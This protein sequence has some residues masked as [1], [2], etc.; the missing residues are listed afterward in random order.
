M[1]PLY[2]FMLA[3][4]ACIQKTLCE[5][6]A[7][8]A[9]LLL[10]HSCSVVLVK[11]FSNISVVS[12]LLGSRKTAS[13]WAGWVGEAAVQLHGHQCTVWSRWA[14]T[15]GGAAGSNTVTHGE[16]IHTCFYCCRL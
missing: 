16:W 14:Q 15:A 5:Q 13:S 1:K 10:R 12:M 9:T 11:V 4:S 3:F 6:W 7:Y 2:C 8:Y